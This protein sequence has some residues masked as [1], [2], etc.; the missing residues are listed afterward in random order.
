VSDIVEMLMKH[1]GCSLK[2]YCDTERVLTIGFG[3]NLIDTGISEEEAI[4]MLHN[5]IGIHSRELESNYFWFKELNVNRQNALIDMHFNLGQYKFSKFVKML[6]AIEE[7]D[8]D[9]AAKEMI[10]SKWAKQVKGR[11]IELSDIVKNG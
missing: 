4:L 3:R 1:E 8:F 10:E 2:P 5:D 11:A 9:L 7:R 6:K